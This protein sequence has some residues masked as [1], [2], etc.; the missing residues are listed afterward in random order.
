LIGAT[1]RGNGELGL[2]KYGATLGQCVAVA[3][4][5]KLSA[6][7]TEGLIEDRA[8]RADLDRYRAILAKV[9]TYPL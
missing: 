3:P 1:G 9:R 8:S 2:I 5:E 7:P 4:A 6:L